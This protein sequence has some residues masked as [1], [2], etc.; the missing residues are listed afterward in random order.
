MDTFQKEKKYTIYSKHFSVEVPWHFIESCKLF[1]DMFEVTDEDNEDNE[2]NN[3]FKITDNFS[4][5]E[6][7]NYLDIYE[8]IYKLRVT[9]NEG[10]VMSYLYYMINHTDEFIE[11][12]T[13][14]NKEPPHC[15]ELASIYEKYEDDIIKT[16]LV[17]DYFNNPY[18]RKGIMLCITCFVKSADKKLDTETKESNISRQIKV[19]E[20][21]KTMIDC[22]ED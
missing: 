11:R 17:D 8:N 10:E 4:S 19:N 7:K 21:I 14:K 3:I 9:N 2:D 13:N 20:L 12:Y 16:L 18:F 22:Y 1:H 5:Q 6:F 15:N